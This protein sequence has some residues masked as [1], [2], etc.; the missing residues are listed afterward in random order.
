VFP[1]DEGDVTLIFPEGISPTG[2]LDLG[3]YLDI[4]L[5][6]EARKKR[7]DDTAALIDK[8]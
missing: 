1:I 8:A 2:L 7:A 3:E 4:F 6:K 5:K